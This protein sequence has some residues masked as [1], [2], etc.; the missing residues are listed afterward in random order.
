MACSA[1]SVWCSTAAG[2]LTSIN[3]VCFS[4]KGTCQ[5]IPSFQQYLKAHPMQV[6]RMTVGDLRR[7]EAEVGMQPSSVA[8]AV[9]E[10]PA[11]EGSKLHINLTA[12]PNTASNE[13]PVEARLAESL[14]RKLPVPTLP[15]Q[16]QSSKQ[17]EE[18]RHPVV[19]AITEAEVFREAPQTPSR[20]IEPN[21]SVQMS[22]EES[23]PCTRPALGTSRDEVCNPE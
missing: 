1:I 16:Q 17:P 7:I 10:K 11:M 4:N 18:P 8:A 14:P 9:D 23:E 13:P 15:V 22:P 2:L 6:G 12:P 19:Q 21:N 3:A 20:P 5:S